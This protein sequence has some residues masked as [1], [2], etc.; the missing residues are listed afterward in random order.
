M[1]SDYDAKKI[2]ETRL[3]FMTLGEKIRFLRAKE[4]ITQEAL[5]E[6]LNVSRSAIAKW[7]V[8]NGTPDISNLKMISKMFQVS[9]DDL[10]ND[11]YQFGESQMKAA[12]SESDDCKK[13]CDG[14][15]CFSDD[16]YKSAGHEES[17]Y[18]HNIELKGWNDGV[19]DVLII[20]EDKDFIYYQKKVKENILYG[21]IGKRHVKSVNRSLKCSMSPEIPEFEG[22][23][24]FCSKHVLLE[25]AAKEGIIK[26]FFDFRNDDYMDVVINSFTD[27]TVSLKYGGDISADAVSK[28][29]ELAD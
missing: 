7:E 10:L 18:Y 28:I 9:L 19:F 5:A 25:V 24:Y 20:G 15:D 26:G 8:N 29:E 27:T 21:L 1:Y 13:V 4:S 3:I 22:R 23:N 2:T 17:G 11:E 6:K 14:N 16:G 12:I